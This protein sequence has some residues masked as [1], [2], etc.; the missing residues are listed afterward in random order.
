[1]ERI[2][3]GAFQNCT[4][5]TQIN[6]PERVVHI[7][8][9]V[10][11]ENKFL[12]EINVH[13]YNRQYSSE[14]GAL[15]N[16]NKTEIIAF[17]SANGTVTIPASV[18]SIG[19]SAFYNCTALDNVVFEEESHIIIIGDNA[20]YNCM[21][22]KSITIPKS[23]FRISEEAFYNCVNLSNV[24]FDDESQLRII[25][26]GAFFNCNS[27]NNII[28]PQFTSNIGNY[29]FL[30]C[31]SL[32]SIIIPQRVT[33]INSNAFGGC[34]NLS[35]VLFDENSRLE[36]IGESAFAYTGIT[37]ITIPQRV[38]TINEAAFY[39]CENLT[40]L[41]FENGSQIQNIAAAVF[42]GCPEDIKIYAPRRFTVPA[43]AFENWLDR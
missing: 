35:S 8:I 5:L 20:F 31:E 42:Y 1:L 11:S 28:L 4:S 12:T 3:D 6:I 39:Y 41:T 21:N 29:A 18:T 25:S 33:V 14:E 40:S 26:D 10:F 16:A 34:K 43:R 15:F 23:L 22:L 37:E 30:N 32:E 19:N 38:T 7:G 13:K 9:G 27:L 24:I 2:E 36:T 17:P